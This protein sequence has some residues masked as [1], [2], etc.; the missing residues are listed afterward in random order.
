MCVE[1]WR[2]VPQ[3]KKTLY[4]RSSQQFIIV[5]T[6][7]NSSGRIKII[8]AI[9]YRNDEVQFLRE[10]RNLCINL[11]SFCTT[12]PGY[13]SRYLGLRRSVS[14]GYVGIRKALRLSRGARRPR[15][16]SSSGIHYCVCVCLL[17]QYLLQSCSRGGRGIVEDMRYERR[18][19]E[20][21]VD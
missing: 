7:Y 1:I 17:L 5:M 8:S 12:I 9:Y 19:A 20:V 21:C 2:D 6:K 18:R 15:R 10:D 13:V 4:S 3:Y 11:S 14:Q 16:W